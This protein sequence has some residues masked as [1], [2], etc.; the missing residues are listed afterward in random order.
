MAGRAVAIQRGKTDIS[1]SVLEH[2]DNYGTFSVLSEA[3]VNM[4]S[5]TGWFKK[6]M[7]ENTTFLSLLLH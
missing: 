6:T 2:R 7:L 1:V 5:A 3:E 4:L